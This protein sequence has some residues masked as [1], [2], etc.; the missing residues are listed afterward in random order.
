[1]AGYQYLKCHFREDFFQPAVM[2][3]LNKLSFLLASKSVAVLIFF[4]FWHS[5]HPI[6]FSTCYRSVQEK[7][8]LGNMRCILRNLLAF[9]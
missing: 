8:N 6:Q 2:T 1:M 3:I 7:V 9:K 4:Q 5:P